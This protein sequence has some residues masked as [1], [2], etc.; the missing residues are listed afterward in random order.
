MSVPQAYSSWAAEEKRE[1]GHTFSTEETDEER[2]QGRAVDL[3]PQELIG[4]IE[5]P[6]PCDAAH[7]KHAAEHAWILVI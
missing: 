4:Q 1:T 3:V 7:L 2:S 5:A 6:S